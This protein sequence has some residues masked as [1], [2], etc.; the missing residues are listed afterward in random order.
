[1]EK[2]QKHLAIG[3]WRIFAISTDNVLGSFLTV[4]LYT[5]MA[6]AMAMARA[7]SLLTIG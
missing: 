2:N 7:S 4:A 1:M 3:Y 6:M 5:D